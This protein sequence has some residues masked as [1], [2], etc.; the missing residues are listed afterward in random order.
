MKANALIFGLTLA[1]GALGI[2]AGGTASAATA[3]NIN[4]NGNSCKNYN[5][6]DVQDIDYYV[7]GV[8]NINVDA[9]YVICPLAS[10]PVS[11]PGQSFIVDGSNYNGY[12][13]TCTIYAYDFN[14]NF[15]SSTSFTRSDAIYSNATQVSSVSYWGYT[16][17]L[18]LLPGST[19]GI[20]RGVTTIDS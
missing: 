17:M 3:Q 5:A 16:S 2:G 11:G 9:R 4:A 20:L 6:W 8:R 19:G 1:A 10:H 18:C 12:S 14:G 15:L 7:H 13:T